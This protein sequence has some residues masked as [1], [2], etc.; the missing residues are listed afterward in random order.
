MDYKHTRYVPQA[1][2]SGIICQQYGTQSNP[3]AVYDP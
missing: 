3:K 2:S 1:A